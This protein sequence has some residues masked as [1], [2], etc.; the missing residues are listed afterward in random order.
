MPQPNRKNR[1]KSNKRKTAPF[2]FKE[3][4]AVLSPL[5]GKFKNRACIDLGNKVKCSQRQQKHIRQAKE[6]G[7][8]PRPYAG[9]VTSHTADFCAVPILSNL[10]SIIKHEMGMCV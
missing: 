8:P 7:N 9:E 3:N 6:G 1:T 2:L 5:S 4:E 10:H